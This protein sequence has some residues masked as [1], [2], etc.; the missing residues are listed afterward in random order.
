MHAAV[1]RTYALTYLK[2]WTH[3]TGSRN[4]LSS[5]ELVILSWVCLEQRGNL[6]MSPSEGSAAPHCLIHFTR[7]A[8]SKAQWSSASTQ[9]SYL[10]M[11]SLSVSFTSFPHKQH[12]LCINLYKAVHQGP[13]LIGYPP[14]RQNQLKKLFSPNCLSPLPVYLCPRFL[15]QLS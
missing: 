7:R 3:C 12:S 2:Q 11:D 8:V 9:H 13:V 5:R 10:W 14:W 6:C 4:T 15:F 1:G